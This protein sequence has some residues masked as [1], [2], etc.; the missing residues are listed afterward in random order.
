MIQYHIDERD[1][2]TAADMLRA[3]F[4]Q[5]PDKDWLDAMLVRWAV[6][7]YRQGDMKTSLEKAQRLLLE[8]PDSPQVGLMTQLVS[9][10]AQRSNNQ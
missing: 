3:V 1:Y 5:H 9:R 6:M 2:V 7:A 8:Y 4:E 10:I